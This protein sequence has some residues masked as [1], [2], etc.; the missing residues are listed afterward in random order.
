VEDLPEST[1]NQI[2]LEEWYRSQMRDQIQQREREKYTRYSRLLAFLN[3]SFGLW[4]LS[5]LFITGAG[6]A[7]TR[8]RSAHEERQK[9]EAQLRAEARNLTELKSR[10]RLEIGHRISQT[11]VLLWNLSDR[12]NPSR[13]GTGHNIAEVRSVLTSFQNGNSQKLASLYPEFANQNTL[14]LLTDLRRLED[15][16]KEKLDRAVAD[17]SGLDVLLDVEK[18]SLSNPE[19]VAGA[20]LKRFSSILWGDFYFIDCAPEMPFC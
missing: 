8:W 18:V 10:F 9:Y 17:L 11:L 5:A 16:D 20:I 12:R 6:S 7:Y 4:L 2:Q 15:Q 19:S 1:K 13:L 14:G 3:S